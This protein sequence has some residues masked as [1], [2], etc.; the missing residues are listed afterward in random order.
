MDWKILFLIIFPQH[1]PLQREWGQYVVNLT[2][3]ENYIRDGAM[4]VQISQ[5]QL[6]FLFVVFI[7]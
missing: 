2:L 6:W 5:A 7:T 1:L 4:S 3:I